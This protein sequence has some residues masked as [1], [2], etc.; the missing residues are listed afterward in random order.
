MRPDLG[1]Q[2]TREIRERISRELGNDPRRLVEHY[3]DYQRRFAD[4]LRPAPAA[5]QVRDGEAPP[6]D[7]ADPRSTRRT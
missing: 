1:L 3:M 5:N 6:A 7:P 2:A 4:R